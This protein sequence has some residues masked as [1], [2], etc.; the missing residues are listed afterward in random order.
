M[1]YHLARYLL[2]NLPPEAA[3]LIALQ[4]LKF[5]APIVQT[6]PQ[7]IASKKLWDIN[8]PNPVGLAAGLD[9]NGDYI[10]PLAKL[11]FGYIELGTVTP[12]PQPGNPKPRLF[13]ITEAQAIINSMGFNNKGVDYLIER[14]KQAKFNG[15]LG[16]NIGKNAHTD[17]ES[18][19]E[20][21]LFCLRK[22][23]PVASYVSVNI[24]SPNTLDLRKLQNSVYLAKLLKALK[25]EQ[26]QLKNKF[27]KY[28]PVLL[29]ISPDL[30]QNEIAD[31]A[32]LLLHYEIDGVIATNTTTS[33][34]KIKGMK[35]ADQQ[36]G[37]SGKPL[38]EQSTYVVQQLSAHLNKKIPIIACGGIMSEKDAREKFTAG[39]DL[40]QLYTGFIYHGPKLIKDILKDQRTLDL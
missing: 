2:F 26:L 9:K 5:L 8:F 28:V 6:N 15:V 11:G 31:I 24:S 4:T 19:N 27:K 17:L 29:K 30:M 37:L 7:V 18:A 10:V 3:H 12:R 40:I 39:A 20:D 35:Y 38:K 36:G 23:Y 16:I 14:I 25:K 22:V 1:F 21:Y 13:R 32:S 33:R 34:D